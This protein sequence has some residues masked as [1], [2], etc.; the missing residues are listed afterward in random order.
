MHSTTTIAL[1]IFVYFLGTIHSIDFQLNRQLGS[2][3]FFLSGQSPHDLINYGCWCS[4]KDKP[5]HAPLDEIDQCCHTYQTCNIAEKTDTIPYPYK[6]SYEDGTIEC[7][8]NK[9]TKAHRQCQCD[10]ELAQCLYKHKSIYTT[11]LLYTSDDKCNPGIVLNFDD[12]STNT[13]SKDIPENYHNFTFI[14]GLY[15]AGK[16]STNPTRPSGYATAM[17]SPPNVLF[18]QNQVTIKRTDGQ[19]FSIVSFSAASAFVRN[20]TLTVTGS[21]QYSPIV[22]N[23]TISLQIETRQIVELNWS[24]IDTLTLTGTGGAKYPLYTGT[25]GNCHFAIDDLRF[26]L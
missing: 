9:N 2:M 5:I 20:L 21:R 8:N 13:T 24:G 10:L 7:L 25:C 12:L 19:L 22:F 1:I 6:A 4:N 11:N 23:E 3:V 15:T 17:L 26:R 18:S 16:D 14:G